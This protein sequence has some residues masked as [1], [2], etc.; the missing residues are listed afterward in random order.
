MSSED[1]FSW[2]DAAEAAER[3]YSVSEI[4]AQVKGLLE[5]SLPA[6]WVEG[7]ISQYTHHS[8]GHRYFTLKDGSSQLSAVMFKWQASKLSCEPE[9]GMQALVYGHVSVYERGGRYQFYATQIKPSGV[10][11]LALAFEQLKNRLEAEGLFAEDRKRPLPAYPQKVGVVTSPTG[12]AIRDIVQVLAR[13][14]PG[15]QVVLCPASVQG[16]GAAAEIAKAI[17]DLNQLADVDILIVGRGGGAPEDL[18]PFND[19]AVARTIYQSAK[20]V[21][22]AVGHEI[23]YTISDYVADYRAPTPSAAAEIV[24]SER[25]AL[26]VRV[27]EYR[28]R[29]QSEMKRHLEALEERLRHCDPSRLLARLDDRLQ[30]QNLYLDERRQDLF[31]ALDWFLRT[32]VE[33]MRNAATRLD[34]L[35]P[36]TSL[37][38]GFALA[39]K[40][41]DGGLVRDGADLKSGDKL[42]LR[43]H[44]GGAICSVEEKLDE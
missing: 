34:D 27:G 38:R 15:L 28:D 11:E 1:L 5:E 30:Q 6:C 24:A 14:A 43:F 33:A 7:E 9:Q 31:T 26:R 35:S 36:L 29:L 25:G 13:R 23:D 17:A 20:P 37:A 44:R 19:E 10:G 39:E 3:P 2:T 22:S 18:W 16:E 32:R 41:A 4:T 42:H 12:A 21:I 40:V 8:S